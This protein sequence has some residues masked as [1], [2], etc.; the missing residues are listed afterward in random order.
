[1]TSRWPL[2]E[3]R[4]VRA[5]WPPTMTSPAGASVK[6][7]PLSDSSVVRLRTY[8]SSRISSADSLAGSK[9]WPPVFCRTRSPLTHV[10]MPWRPRE[11]DH[12]EADAQEGGARTLRRPGRPAQAP[13]RLAEE[14][15]QE[16]LEGP[17]PR[18]HGEG[19]VGPG[20]GTGLR[21]AGRPGGPAPLARR[22]G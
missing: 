11:D 6:P 8:N 9:D 20:E 1:M 21:G 5:G 16:L 4:T 7:S 19:R 18:R 17:Q 2:A 10:R 13:G 22:P 14:E 12:E 15:P 3:T